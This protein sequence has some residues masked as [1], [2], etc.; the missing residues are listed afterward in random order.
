MQRHDDKDPGLGGTNLVMAYN[1]GSGA[2]PGQIMLTDD[3][4]Q[5]GVESKKFKQRECRELVSANMPKN[6]WEQEG[7]GGRGRGAEGNSR[8]E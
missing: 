6:R 5:S 4:R 8:R 2:G 3:T 1:D 7:I